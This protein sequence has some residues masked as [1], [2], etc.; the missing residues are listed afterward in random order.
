MRAGQL[1]PAAPAPAVTVNA[2]RVSL[3]HACVPIMPCWHGGTLRDAF[4]SSYPSSV[5]LSVG[6]TRLQLYTA[7]D[8]RDRRNAV[9]ISREILGYAT[10]NG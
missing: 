7:V 4:M 9:A 3:E 2:Q 1:W 10:K 5:Y 8:A 6:P